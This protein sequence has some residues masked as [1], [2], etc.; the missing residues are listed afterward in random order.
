MAAGPRA[1]GAGPSRRRPAVEKAAEESLTASSL[2]AGV[3]ASAASGSGHDAGE[4][5]AAASAGACEAS[6]LQ[7]TGDAVQKL[8][9]Q[10]T[11]CLWVL[12][13]TTSSKDDWQNSQ[14][15]VHA[16]S[17]VE[18]FWRGFNNIK[19]PSRL[20]N[21]DF[22]VFKKDIAP[23]W[24]DETCRQGGRWM[25]K[26]DK[27]RPEDF[28]ELWLNVILT[29]IGEGFGGP[30]L[31]VC[32]AVVSSRAKN[33]KMALW[34]SDK[35]EEKAMPTGQAFHQILQDAGFVGEITFENFDTQTKAYSIGKK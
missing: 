31:C 15:N 30:G 4:V 19:S 26:I 35:S 28:D 12:Q 24:E 23:A 7:A 21:I 6:V 16:F 13:Y 32:G 3:T 14:M 27:L 8:L 25:A 20:G 5:K 10:H 18:D 33:C 1:E 9:L 11:W 2:A 29:M 17:T 22:S 34:L